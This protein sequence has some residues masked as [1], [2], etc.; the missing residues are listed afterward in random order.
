MSE[1]PQNSR[2]AKKLSVISGSHQDSKQLAGCMLRTYKL[3]LYASIH[4][5][6]YILSIK[7]HIVEKK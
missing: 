5:A 3:A 2:T 1:L 6:V 4:T 7:K